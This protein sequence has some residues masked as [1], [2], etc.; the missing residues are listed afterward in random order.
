LKKKQVKDLEEGEF[1]R[2]SEDSV[3]DCQVVSRKRKGASHTLTYKQYGEE[4]REDFMGRL[5][6]WVYG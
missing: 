2:W 6:V 3:T 5:V 1:F 4:Y